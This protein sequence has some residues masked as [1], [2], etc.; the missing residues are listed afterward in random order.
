MPETTIRRAELADAHTLSELGRRTFIE[1]FVEG[2]AVG[3]PPGDLAPFLESAYAPAAIASTLEDPLCAAWIAERGGVALAYATAGPNG[4]PH[5]EATRDDGELYRLYVAREA[6]GTGLGRM[7][8][9]TA[10]A[11]LE[12]DG[13]RRLWIGVWSG[14]LNAQRLYARYGFGK[15]GEY[16]FPVGR[17][18]DREFILRRDADLKS[19]PLRGS[20]QALAPD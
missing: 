5:P 16:E 13:P 4:L 6:Q 19:L 8:L 12:R 20:C 14:N 17:V 18:R 11:W 9:D 7:L 1:T 3:Y 15:V 2:F 10:L